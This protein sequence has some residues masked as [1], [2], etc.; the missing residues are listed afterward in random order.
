M[1]LLECFKPGT[2]SWGA[3]L[4]YQSRHWTPHLLQGSPDWHNPPQPWISPA[5]GLVFPSPSFPTLYNPTVLVTHSLC[6][7]EPPGCCTCSS[8]PSPLLLLGSGSRLL[9]TLPDV[10]ASGYALPHASNKL[11]SPHLGTIMFFPFSFRH[12]VTMPG[13][14]ADLVEYQ[15]VFKT[16]CSK[17]DFGPGKDVHTKLQ[18]PGL[19]KLW[20][21]HCR[22]MYSTRQLVIWLLCHE[23]KDAMEPLGTAAPCLDLR[24]Q[25]KE[26]MA[27]FSSQASCLFYITYLYWLQSYHTIII[28]LR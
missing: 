22:W 14:W 1:T 18:F 23:P 16:S 17:L 8:L 6:T 5:Q 13:G 19:N 24:P 26:I 4:T 20:E 9:W 7:F 28:E 3:C 2:S 15:H 21:V 12:Q 11:S 27:W 25:F 10:P